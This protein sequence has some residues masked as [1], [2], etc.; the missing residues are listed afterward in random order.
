M[1]K[2]TDSPVY[3]YDGTQYKYFLQLT[4]MPHGPQLHH[5]HH[6][7]RGPERKKKKKINM[8]LMQQLIMM[9]GLWGVI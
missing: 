4:L 1:I 6:S 9:A 2:N 8:T 7:Q 3:W 5:K